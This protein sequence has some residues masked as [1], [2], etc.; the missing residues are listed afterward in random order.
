MLPNVGFIWSLKP[1]GTLF[2]EI[3]KM[4]IPNLLLKKF[5]PQKA[6]LSDPKLKAFITHC[7]AN[8]VIEA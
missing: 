6:L 2:Y 8:S 1:I 7:G 5:V 4:P 3:E